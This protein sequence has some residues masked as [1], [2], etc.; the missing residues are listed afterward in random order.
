MGFVKISATDISTDDQRHNDRSYLGLLDSLQSTDEMTRRWAARDL[1]AFPQASVAL[2]QQLT[3]EPDRSVREAIFV[4]LTQIGDQIAVDG[5]ITCLR[6]EVVNLRNDA[7]EAM[8]LM[9][10]A[11][12][13]MMQGLLHDSDPDIRI[14]AVNILESLRHPKVESWLIDVITTDPHL[15]VCATALDLLAEVGSQQAIE[16]LQQLKQKFADEPFVQFAIDIALT[17]IQGA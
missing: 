12:A 5:L 3:Q 15:N 9:P 7:I 11:V 17:R 14:F 16:P 4:S 10:D 2:M 6:S 1:A 8:K 13:P